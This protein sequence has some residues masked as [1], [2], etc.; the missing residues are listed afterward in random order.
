MNATGTK[1]YEDCFRQTIG[2]E[3]N[4]SSKTDWTPH[5]RI[6]RLMTADTAAPGAALRTTLS[7]YS[8]F[9]KA[10]LKK[11]L[12]REDLVAESEKPQTV[13]LKRWFAKYFL[14]ISFPVTKGG[15]R[16]HYGLSQWLVC[17][18]TD[19]S[20]NKTYSQSVGVG[21]TFPWIERNGV[22]HWGLLM[23]TT[24][25]WKAKDLVTKGIVPKVADA[26]AKWRSVPVEGQ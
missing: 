14:R 26:I 8:L 22:P 10:V 7:D 23:R 20:C 2:T 21:G 15:V 16:M 18:T 12:V 19:K 6:L 24:G 11:S 25:A 5:N 13:G 1:R 9:L 4:M 3:L 17:E